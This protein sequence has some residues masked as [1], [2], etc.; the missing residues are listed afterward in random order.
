MKSSPAP[1]DG[2]M[3]PEGQRAKGYS[4]QNRKRF[5]GTLKEKLVFSGLVSI[6]LSFILLAG[7]YWS[8]M[9]DDNELMWFHLNNTTGSDAQVQ[10][11]VTDP[12]QI[13]LYNQ[14]FRVGPAE[15]V[16]AAFHHDTGNF[17]LVCSV[18]GFEPQAIG[19][20]NRQW[21]DIHVDIT[22]TENEVTLEISEND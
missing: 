4:Q 19:G 17:S 1:T 20:H 14:D 22:I 2:L 5:P 15:W 6:G 11:I 21:W 9:W 7:W 16:D 12:E 18:L 13:E 8:I 3:F 10:I